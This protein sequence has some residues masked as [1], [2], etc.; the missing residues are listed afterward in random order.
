MGS[1]DWGIVVFAILDFVS[2]FVVPMSQK[3]THC[4]YFISIIQK[5]FLYIVPCLLVIHCFWDGFRWQLYPLYFQLFLTS[6]ATRLNLYLKPY[7]SERVEN[8]NLPETVANITL[9][10]MQPRPF[11]TFSSP[12]P[13]LV[14]S[15]NF[16]VRF[17]FFDYLIKFLNT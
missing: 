8:V 16:W 2:N 10:S 11:S 1:R 4:L 6:V 15:L 9:H 3:D 5:S 17:I 12:F 7:K 13:M 14:L